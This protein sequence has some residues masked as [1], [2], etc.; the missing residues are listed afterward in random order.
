MLLRESGHRT[1]ED[2]DY[3][4][5]DSYESPPTAISL[6]VEFFTNGWI[7]LLTDS[8]IRMYLTLK[9]LAS[10][11]PREH[12]LRGIYCIDRDR[13]WLYGVSRDVYEAH[14]TLARFGLIEL[15]QNDSRHKDGKIVNYK[16]F[17]KK[18]AVPLPPHRFQI[19]PD[20]SFYRPAAEK[21]KRALL[22]YPPSVKQMTRN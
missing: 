18:G 22:N 17:L 16:E 14:L 2:H 7:H 3:V 1:G 8:E 12:S 19:L 4:I 13:E 15:V 10:R 21:I 20:N 6:P 11:Y 5:P 9:H